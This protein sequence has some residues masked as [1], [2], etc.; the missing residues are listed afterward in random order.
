[1]LVVTATALVADA[2]PW[3]KQGVAS[4]NQITIQIVDAT[5][6]YCVSYNQ[7]P[8]QLQFLLVDTTIPMVYATIRTLQLHLA[9]VVAT[10][11]YS[12]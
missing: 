3:D 11:S 10:N 9:T 12:S 7:N 2:I 6:S 1:M 8:L 5:N 4:G